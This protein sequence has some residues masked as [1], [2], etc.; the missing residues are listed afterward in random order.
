MAGRGAGP[1]GQIHRLWQ[2]G[3]V[4]GMTD[5]Q[6]LARFGARQED[7]AELA[8]EALMER[9]GPMV[10]RICRGILGDEHAAEDAFQATFLVLA[11]TARSLWVR[12]SL[13]SWLHGVAHRI[14]ARARVD[15]ARRRRH[16]QRCAEAR[17]PAIVVTPDH[18]ESEAW[19]ILSEEIAR[20]PVTYRAPVVLCYLEAMSYQA[21][22]ACLGVTEDTVR[23]RLARAR[24]R[25]R[26]GLTRRGVEVPAV[27][28]IARPAIPAFVVRS[29][30]VQAT[31]RAAADLSTGGAASLG[32]FS[33]SVISLYERACRTMM[34][35]KLKLAAAI[36]VLGVVTAGTIVSAKQARDAPAAT[37][38]SAKTETKPSKAV[39]GKGGNFIVDWTPVGGQSAKKQITVDSTRHCI[40][41]SAVSTKLEDRQNDGAVRVDL[42]RGKVYKITAAGQAFESKQ[43]GPDADPFQ[44]V[45][46]VYPTDEEDGY[47]TRQIVLSPGK[48][49]AF[50]APWLI[51]PK[52]EV[53]LLA[54]FLATSLDG[55]HGSYTLTIEDTGEP[56]FKALPEGKIIGKDDMF[57]TGPPPAA[58]KQDTQP[59]TAPR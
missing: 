55:N 54:F 53:F 27:L 10:F 43:T 47:A 6:L 19:A 36:V 7:G 25:L 17:G 49:I 40:L 42:E 16:E 46:V 41:L 35:T 5:A 12:D 59:R 23:G 13:G 3:T 31:A 2:L 32:A 37:S 44:G 18:P 30:L 8:F 39:A 14:A 4:A 20:L 56:A 45:V 33:R 1:L 48:S 21:A 58:I 11:R 57:I 26:R 38:D 52:D 51:S 22:A 9:H 15:A 29:E 24:Q 34:L 28:A 50:R